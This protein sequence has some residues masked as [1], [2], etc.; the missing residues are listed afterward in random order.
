MFTPIVSSF[1]LWLVHWKL[2]FVIVFSF[3][4]NFSFEFTC[5]YCCGPFNT[6][7]GSSL[8]TNWKSGVSLFSISLQLWKSKN[9]HSPFDIGSNYQEMKW[10]NGF[11][12]VDLFFPIVSVFMGFVLCVCVFAVCSLFIRLVCLSFEHLKKKK[13]HID[14]FGVPRN[15]KKRNERVAI[16]PE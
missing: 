3:I 10:I 8:I 16:F 1:C 11:G 7:I 12:A 4:F 14:I 9:F 2:C 6:S 15:L 13:I 5:N